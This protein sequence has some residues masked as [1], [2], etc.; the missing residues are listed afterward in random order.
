MKSIIALLIIVLNTSV[1]MA[2]D[3]FKMNTIYMVSEVY[4]GDTVKLISDGLS[5]PFNKI[6]LRLKGIDTPEKGGRARCEKEA[7]QA[8]DA[9]KYLKNLLKSNDYKIK[10]DKWGKYGGR[11]IGDIILINHPYGE[12]KVSDAMIEQGYAV[13]YDGGKKTH[14]WCKG[15]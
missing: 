12:I 13:R 2:Y 7:T 4:D 8:I 5:K 6:S 9:T 14:D 15:E 3:T 11:I 10:F 1:S